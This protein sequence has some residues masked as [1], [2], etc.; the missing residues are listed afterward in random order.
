MYMLGRFA[1]G[2][3]ACEQAARIAQ[4]T[5]D[6]LL[7]ARSISTSANI[8]QAQGDLSEALTQHRRALEIV[9]RIGSRRDAAGALINIGNVQ[10]AQGVHSAAAQSYQAGLA[11]AREIN[12]QALTQT[13]LNNLAG[14]N[15]I[16]GNFTVALSLFQK[17]LETARAIHDQAGTGRALSNI[18]SIYS[19]QGNFS[20]A[21]QNIQDA[22]KTGQETGLKSDQVGFLYAMGDT[23]LAQGDLAAA[24]SNYQSGQGLAT[25]INDNINVAVGQLSVASL[26]LQQG[27]AGEALPL[28]RQ[29]ADAFHTKGMKDQESQSR[30]L[31][32]SCLLDLRKPE[33]AATELQA[34]QN[35]SPQD[36]TIKLAIAITASRIA[37][38]GGKTAQ[39]RKEL[40][41][42]AAEARRMGIPGLQFEA[43]LAQGELGL[44]GGDRSAS[45]AVLSS[46][47]QEASRKGYKQFEIRAGGLAEQLRGSKPS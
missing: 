34:A 17:S 13:L 20:A 43:R 33:E 44:F 3:T 18:G 5:G 38:R 32:A 10:S 31:V 39:S 7:L 46:L 19:L 25:R 47:Q 45:I 36:P 12:D 28:A 24:E 22:M 6:Q 40:E 30:N 27:K 23:K 16:I 29:A 21:L 4:A 8:A 9:R 1:P 37:V 15:Q 41:S 14:E 2:K 11:E 35:L 26:R 42:V